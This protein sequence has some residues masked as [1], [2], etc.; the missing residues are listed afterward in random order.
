MTELEELQE[1]KKRGITRQQYI[2]RR[3]A[4]RAVCEPKTQVDPQDPYA[5]NPFLEFT[6]CFEREMSRSQ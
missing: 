5:V 6:P 1:A 2:Q 4:A 3:N